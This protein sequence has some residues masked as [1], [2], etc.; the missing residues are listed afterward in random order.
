MVLSG[1]VPGETVWI[2]PASVLLVVEVVS[3]GSAKLDRVIKPIEY[4]N[5]GIPRYWRVERGGNRAT[6]HMYRLGPDE[7]GEPA[8][9]DHEV[10]L[11]DKLLAGAPPEL[12]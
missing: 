4:A 2:D 11:L 3:R 7:R 6:V 5:A 9:V 1:H 8:Y 10:V 12:A